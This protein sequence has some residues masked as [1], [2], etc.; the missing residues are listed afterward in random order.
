MH[1]N[2]NFEYKINLNNYPYQKENSEYI[3]DNFVGNSSSTISNSNIYIK[4]NKYIIDKIKNEK[5]KIFIEEEN[6]NYKIKSNI[7]KKEKIFPIFY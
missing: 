3:A 2:T 4:K 1:L 5:K 7:R 6:Q